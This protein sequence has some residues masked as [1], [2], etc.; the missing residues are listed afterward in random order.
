MRPEPEAA[1]SVSIVIDGTEQRFSFK[2][3]NIHFNDDG[4][5]TAAVPWWQLGERRKLR[6]LRRFLGCLLA[7]RHDLQLPGEA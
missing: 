6:R 7:S 3:V 1:D 2:R 4:S 5:F